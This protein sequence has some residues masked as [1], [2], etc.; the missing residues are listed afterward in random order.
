MFLFLN[1]FSAL[2][3]TFK[4]SLNDLIEWSLE[5]GREFSYLLLSYIA[6][7]K[8]NALF[9]SELQNQYQLWSCQ[10]MCEALTYL[11]DNIFIC[12]RTKL[13]RQIVGILVGTNCAPLTADMF[14]FC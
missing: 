13:Y 1:V 14:L 10:N 2:E 4:I 5:K 9:T 8:T 6:C 12:F 7:N 3:G 11:L